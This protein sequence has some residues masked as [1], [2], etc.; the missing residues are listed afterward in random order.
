[1]RWKYI[2][3]GALTF[4]ILCVFIAAGVV[5]THMLTPGPETSAA[6]VELPAFEVEALP[7]ISPTPIESESPAVPETP[8]TPEATDPDDEID[9]PPE[10]PPE[11]VLTA[12]PVRMRIPALSLDY[13]VRPTKADASGTMQIVPALKVISW[14]EVS[15]IPGNR[16]NAIFGGHNRWRGENS[17]IFHLDSLEVGDELEI[18]YDDGTSLRFFMESVFVYPL[19]T[20]PAH[21]IMDIGG[22]ARLTLITCKGPFSTSMGTSENRIVATFKHESVFVIPDPPVE[23]FPPKS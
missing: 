8:E 18:E 11:L 7:E 13:E 14:F 21:L 16:G 5:I 10:E 20:A 4:L 1:M 23:P 9:E 22:E 12:L 17:R 15:A 6:E 3:R 19:I 2:V